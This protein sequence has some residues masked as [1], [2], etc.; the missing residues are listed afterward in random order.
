M[1]LMSLA[2]YSIKISSPVIINFSF[3]VVWPLAAAL[4]PWLSEGSSAYLPCLFEYST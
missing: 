2:T 4:L 1:A 3:L